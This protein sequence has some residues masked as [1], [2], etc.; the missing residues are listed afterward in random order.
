VIFAQANYPLHYKDSNN[1][2]TDRGAEH[3]TNDEVPWRGWIVDY[4][5]AI[6][7]VSD[8][9]GFDYTYRSKGSDVYSASLYTAAVGDVQVGIGEMMASSLWITS[10]RLALTTFTTQTAV[11]RIYLWVPA[12]TIVQSNFLV[13]VLEPFTLGL[14]LCLFGT[15]MAV[16]LLSLW[17]ATPMSTRRT[18]WKELRSPKYEDASLSLRTFM[19]IRVVFDAFLA[20]SSTF[21]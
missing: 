15:I 10:E 5:V 8:I 21:F 6:L 14:W 4:L 3:Y 11:D 18:W 16:S 9:G 19:N 2:D 1:L 13:K 7:E 12:P 17:F 20:N